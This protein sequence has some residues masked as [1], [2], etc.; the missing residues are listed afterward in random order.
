M[1]FEEL[2]EKCEAFQKKEGFSHSLNM[3]ELAIK[4]QLYSSLSKRDD[5][6]VE[7]IQKLKSHVL[8]EILLFLTGV[9]LSDN[10]DVYGA[11]VNALK[12]RE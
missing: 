1:H 12:L 7:E 2:W 10:I 8:G 9:S 5:I 3:S 4:A 6:S 11:L